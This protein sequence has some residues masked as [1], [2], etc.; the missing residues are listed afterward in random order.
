[1]V[2]GLGQHQQSSLR[3]YARAFSRARATGVPAAIPRLDD[4]L[5]DPAFNPLAR[6]LRQRQQQAH[7]PQLQAEI[8]GFLALAQL[9]LLRGWMHWT[10]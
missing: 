8:D 5:A 4:L 6:W 7:V 10:V 1:M 2:A 9:A 3:N